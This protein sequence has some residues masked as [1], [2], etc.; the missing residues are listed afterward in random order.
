MPPLDFSKNDILIEDQPPRL[1]FSKGDT[2]VAEKKSEAKKPQEK[3]DLSGDRPKGALT[4]EQLRGRTPIYSAITGGEGFTGAIKA[5]TTNYPE[6]YAVMPGAVRLLDRAVRARP[7]RVEPTVEPPSAPSGPSPSAPPAPTSPPPEPSG[8]APSPTDVAGLR[9]APRNPWEPPPTESP[10]SSLEEAGLTLP[11]PAT[12]TETVAQPGPD[13][14]MTQVKVQTG[15][16]PPPTAEPPP[17]APETAAEPPV[18]PEGP[19]SLSDLRSQFQNLT[20]EQFEGLFREAAKETPATPETAGTWMSTVQSKMAALAGAKSEEPKTKGPT[21]EGVT[22]EPAAPEP[23]S[24]TPI[25]PGQS[26]TYAAAVAAAKDRWPAFRDRINFLPGENGRPIETSRFFPG[27]Q[28]FVDGYLAAQ[29]GPVPDT[30]PQAFLDGYRA[31]QVA[32]GDQFTPETA[33]GGPWRPLKDENGSTQQNPDGEDIYTNPNGA[34]ATFDDRGVPTIEAFEDLDKGVT[35]K[36][37]KKRSPRFQ[38][39]TEAAAVEEPPKPKGR[40]AGEPAIPS[41]RDVEAPKK[42]D[43]TLLGTNSEGVEVYENPQG[44]RSTLQDGIRSTESVRMRPTANGMEMSVPPPEEKGSEYQVVTPAKAE[45]EVKKPETD[46]LTTPEPSKLEEAGKTRGGRTILKPAKVRSGGAETPPPDDANATPPQVTLRS[47]DVPNRASPTASSGEVITHV[48]KRGRTLTG[49]IRKNISETEAKTLDPA[50]FRKNSGWFIRSKPTKKEPAAEPVSSPAQAATQAGDVAP[51]APPP[52]R[53]SDPA[54][55]EAADLAE[56]KGPAPVTSIPEPKAVDRARVKNELTAKDMEETR[57]FIERVD[58]GRSN[59]TK[60]EDEAEAERIMQML[61]DGWAPEDIA[62]APGITKSPREIRAIDR[63]LD[64]EALDRQNWDEDSGEPKPSWRPREQFS[65]DQTTLRFGDEGEG[66]EGVPAPG[67]DGENGPAP[68]GNRPPGEA[69]DGR[70]AGGQTKGRPGVRKPGGRGGRSGSSKSDT[71]RLP[72]AGKPTD[73]GTTGR[74][75]EEVAGEAKGQDYVIQPGDLDESRTRMTKARDN[76]KAIRLAKRLTAE[77][78]LATADEQKVLVKY[79]GWGGLKNVF[80]DGNGNFGQGMEKIGAEIEALLT[81]EELRTAAR[82]TLNAHYT[83]EHVVRSM[84]E[85]VKRLGFTGGNVFEP[86]MG[87]GH[88]RGLMPPDL[89]EKTQYRGVEMDHLTADIAKLLYP[90]SGVR[91]ADYTQMALPLDAFDLV[92][93]NPPFHEAKITADPRYAA[94]GFMLHDYF[95]AKSLDSVRPGGL[96]AFVTSAGTM[97]KMDP[98]AREYLAERG[99]FLH[100]V[101]LPSSAFREN[102][103]TDVTTDILFFKRRPEGQRPLDQIPDEEKSWIQSIPRSLP[104]PD[105]APRDGVGSRYFSEH[106]EMVLGEEGFFGEMYGSDTN[107]EVRQRPGTDLTTDLQVALSRLPEGVMDP[108]LAQD[109]AQLADFDARETKDGSFYLKDGA[110]YQYSNGAGKPVVKRSKSGGMTAADYERVKKLVPVRD[111]LRRVFKADLAGDE[112]TGAQARADLSKHYDAFVKEFGPINKAEISYHR[113]T[114]VQQENARQEAREEARYVGDRWYEGDFDATP[115][116]ARNATMTEIANARQAARDAKAGRQF[117][118][119]SFD[120]DDMPDTVRD[121]RPNIRAFMKDP[122]SY[123]LRSIEA[124]DDTTGAPNKREIFFRNPTSRYVEPELNSANDGLLW[125]LNALGRFDPQAIADKMGRSMEQIISDLGDLVFEN[126]AAPGNW[127]TRD[128]YL[129]GDVKTKLAQA[130]RIAEQDRRFERNVNALQGAQPVPLGPG[131]ITLVL[132]MPWIPMEAVQDFARDAME[133][134]RPKITYSPQISRWQVEKPGGRWQT[135]TAAGLPKWSTPRRTAYELLADALNRDPP[136][137]YDRVRNPDGGETSIL[138]QE[139]TLTAQDKMLAIQRMFFDPDTRNGWAV[140][141]PTRAGRIADAYNEKMNREVLRQFDGDY[142]TTPGVAGS[143]RW[144]PHQT[145]VISR[146][147]MTGNTYMAHAVGAGKTSAMIGSGMEMKRLGLVKKPMYVVPNHMLGQFTKEFYEQYPSARIAVADD[148]QFH[149]D[150]RRQFMANVAGDDLDAVIIT[151]SSFKKIPVSREFTAEAIQEEIAE[152]VAA[153]KDAKGDRFTVRR[154]Q[155]MQQKLEQKLSKMGTGKDQTLNFEDMGVDFLFVDEAH[156]FRKLPFVTMQGDVKGIDPDGSDAARDLHMKVRYLESQRP[157]RSIVMASGTPVTNTMGELF[158]VSRYLQPDAMKGRDVATFDAWAQTFA[159]TKTALEQNPDG[160]YKPQTRLSQFVNMPEL[161]KMVGGVMDIV[162]SAQLAQYVT[163]P[164][165]KDGQRTFN[166]VDPTP[167]QVAYSAE[168]GRRMKDI[169]ARTGPPQ[170]GDDIILTVINDGRHAAIDP[171]FVA[172][173][174]SDTKSKLNT[175]LSN[176]VQI[177]KDSADTQFYDP[178]SNYEKPSFR[179][180]ATQMIFANLGINP[181]DGGFS[182]Y[183]WIKEYLRRAGVPADQVAFIKDYKTATAR[184]GLFNDVNEGKVRILIGSTQKM[185]TGVNAQRRLLAVHNLDPLWF[186]AD[187][188]QRNGRILRQGNHNP[189]I[190]IHDYAT[191]GSYD[192]TMWQMMGRKAGFI[193]QF[194]RG[195]PNLRDMED[196]GE[197]SMYEQASAMTTSDPRVMQLTQMRLDLKR[198]ILRR[199]G[200]RSN[201]WALNSKLKTHERNAEWFDESATNVEQDI[202]QRQDI[203]GKKFTADIRGETYTDREQFNEA[204]RQAMATEPLAARGAGNRRVTIG[205][206]S[207][208]PIR[209]Y[210]NSGQWI[211]EIIFNGGRDRWLQGDYAA[212]A[213]ALIRGLE[214]DLNGYRTRA[215]DE[216]AAAEAVRPLIGQPFTEDDEINRLDFQVKELESALQAPADAATSAKP[217]ADTG[218]DLND[219]GEVKEPPVSSPEVDLPDDMVPD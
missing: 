109:D 168:L 197:A 9:V 148:D 193:E 102:A 137:I 107:Y 166:Q 53:P 35:P 49:T 164:K 29:S 61:W 7:P 178:A 112:E 211:P 122:E 80:R 201:Q 92:I 21:P 174:Q 214:G 154:L 87:I 139:E 113:P 100:A 115:F 135:D 173:A 42:P 151:H 169:A 68:P 84:W 47:Q 162:T 36:N 85:A 25:K 171:R 41:A 64:N 117:N 33:Y 12:A 118:E 99:E 188:E 13:G 202:A 50:A 95:F 124:Y 144:R 177:W 179:G 19:Q 152:L 217:S 8:A 125:S 167:E 210:Q 205:Q 27:P 66:P 192:S 111:A 136:R 76:V 161:Y 156:G 22:A 155:S 163:R 26:D 189:E 116:Y 71:D 97:N 79:V 198:M 60:S 3:D 34:R 147:I 17:T 14:T 215:A 75:P 207:G 23:T 218:P 216:R 5:L 40:K 132:G 110:L 1:D 105:K 127:Q 186:P 158:S 82:S 212:S 16:P 159:N 94:R 141:D 57:D 175:M 172:P 191:N 6:Q 32:R 206:I 182:T 38:T 88:F 143:W 181:R 145:R 146:I 52:E 43:W 46:Q 213:A 120:P 45:P 119:G 196:L 55:A 24:D 126:H 142:L 72:G 31:A 123:R 10:P 204:I 199:E 62:E 59:Q 44:V 2:L 185:G 93:G 20:D 104:G 37:E 131:Q 170:P 184:Q 83:A 128:E 56:G 70:P 165:L 183:N 203:S 54:V 138:N 98:A 67:P 103:M 114:I 195:D 69:D 187:D 30:A 89:A 133:L 18:Q 200:H 101:R 28:Q 4:D 129:S 208:F 81:P 15:E 63:F 86:G 219:R 77:K 176:V 180:A 149:T 39:Q 140:S 108:P 65:G 209:L 134:G 90:N 48:T 130:Q 91:Q 157:G 106:P 121:H 194:F 11:E 190:Q 58:Y 150:R 78:R 153:I 160:S 74:P 96:L 73:A 51:P